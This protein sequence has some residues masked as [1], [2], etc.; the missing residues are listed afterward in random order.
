MKAR[1]VRL[2][3][4]VAS[5][6]YYY[7]FNMLD[8]Q[9]G[10][11]SEQKRLLRQAISSCIDLQTYIR[12]FFNG[13]G[14]IPQSPVPP[15]IFGYREKVASH[16]GFDLKKAKDLLTKAG[17]KDGIDP[18]TGQPLEIRYDIS[19]VAGSSSDSRPQLQYLQ[20]QFE[21]VGLRLK[22]VS[23]DLNTYRRKIFDGNYQMFA[24]GWLPDYPDPENFLFLLYGPNANIPNHSENL[25][26]YRNA[27]YD[28]LF[29]RM[30]AMENTPGR[31]AII[32]RMEDI[33]NADCPW[34]Y[35]MHSVDF[36][37]FHAW[38]LNNV[39]TDI[40]N[41]HMKYKRI[42]PSLR[43]A[44]V[45]KYNRPVYWPVILLCLLMAV[46]LIPAVMAVRRKYK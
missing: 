39:T 12:I 20:E 2:D 46:S 41:N 15:E 31:L 30:K 19:A 24:L 6:I 25:A 29:D 44:Y 35:M 40:I 10:G 27:E 42:V 22:I 21:R 37:L 45:R 36:T 4:A 16:F 13:R 9:V 32:H 43:T 14:L 23:S 17:Y 7:A 38:Y 5:D 11:Y 26:N 8:P 33:V 28:S 18:A 1:G 3:T 34:I